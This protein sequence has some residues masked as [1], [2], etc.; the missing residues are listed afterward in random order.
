MLVREGLNE[1]QPQQPSKSLLIIS[2]VTFHCERINEVYSVIECIIYT[3]NSNKLIIVKILQRH[4]K[5]K[6]QNLQK[7]PIW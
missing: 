4:T 1:F 5:F 6:S 3:G 7:P 2:L